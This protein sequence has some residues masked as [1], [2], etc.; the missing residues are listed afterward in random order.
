MPTYPVPSTAPPPVP[1]MDV[2]VTFDE[3]RCAY[4]G[5]LVVPDGALLRFRFVLTSSADPRDWLV[6][7]PIEPSIDPESLRWASSAGEP[8]FP[9]SVAPP[10][11]APLGRGQS[12]PGSMLVGL[13]YDEYL[14][15]PG[16][17]GYFVGCATATTDLM[18]PG[19]VIR[20][21]PP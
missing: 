13:T 4:A 10:W 5:P 17:V 6:V 8:G 21:T 19:A 7:V 14:P 2:T 20:V 1:I 12:G 16:Q 15:V 9:A 3:A 11:S 18:Y